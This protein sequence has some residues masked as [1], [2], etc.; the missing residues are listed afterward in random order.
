M[1]NLSGIMEQVMLEGL[2]IQDLEEEIALLQS[3][4]TVIDDEGDASSCS[5]SL[6]KD[7]PERLIPFHVMKTTFPMLKE[8]GIEVNPILPAAEV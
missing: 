6:R 2:D 4:E 7:I 1:M 3:L 5:V 8:K